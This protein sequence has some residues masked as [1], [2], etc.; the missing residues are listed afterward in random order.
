MHGTTVKI[1]KEIT[2]STWYSTSQVPEN[3]EKEPYLVTVGLLKL[4]SCYKY[5]TIRQL[6]I[7]ALSHTGDHCMCEVFSVE[8]RVFAVICKACS[9]Q[10]ILLLVNNQLDA[11]FF[12]TYV[13]FYSLHVSGSH[14]PIIRRI[15]ILAPEFYI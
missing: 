8:Q 14:V 7:L 3:R 15:N 13:Y 9:R 10:R 6:P 2:Y 5:R 11:Q 1:K 12:F 4:F